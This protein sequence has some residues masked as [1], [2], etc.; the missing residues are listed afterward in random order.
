MGE[1]I[2]EEEKALRRKAIADGMALNAVSGGP[3]PQGLALELYDKYIEGEFSF[4]EL[5]QGLIAMYTQ[6]DK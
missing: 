3:Q 6:V 1:K 5:E 4:E 2:S